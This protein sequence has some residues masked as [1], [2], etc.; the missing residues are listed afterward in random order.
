M[1][2]INSQINGLEG[3]MKASNNLGHLVIIRKK[4]S[5]LVELRNSSQKKFKDVIDFSIYDDNINNNTNVSPDASSFSSAPVDAG[6]TFGISRGVNHLFI[7]SATPDTN[8][9]SIDTEMSDTYHIVEVNAEN[10]SDNYESNSDSSD[11]E[12][13]G[14]EEEDDDDKNNLEYV[15]SHILQED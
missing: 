3:A 10:N 2:N 9:T 11:A 5:Y 1:K 15:V 14:E 13:E 12:E 6:D 8:T 7:E 4:H